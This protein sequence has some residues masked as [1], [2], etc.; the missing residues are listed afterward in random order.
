MLEKNADGSFTFDRSAAKIG[1]LTADSLFE[2][3]VQTYNGKP[4]L[5]AHRISNLAADGSLRRWI[6]RSATAARARC[7]RR[8]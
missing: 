3:N 1:T 2:R 7:A 4:Y 5:E 8:R 6:A